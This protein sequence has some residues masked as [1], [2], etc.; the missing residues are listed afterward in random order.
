MITSIRMGRNSNDNRRSPTCKEAGQMTTR[1][2]LLIV[3][4]LLFHDAQAQTDTSH[5]RI[6]MLTCGIGNET[7]ET[8]GHTGI[9]VID[10]AQPIV[11]RDLVYNYGTFDY[12]DGS[13]AYKFL[14]GDL[15]V[16]LDTINYSFFE[17]MFVEEQRSMMEQVLLLN[18]EQKARLL[19]ALKKN[20]LPEN[21]YYT[22]DPLSNNCT[23]KTRDLFY[24]TFGSSIV[25]KDPLP[26]NKRPTLRNCYNSYYRNRYWEHVS[27]NL[28]LAS[29]MDTVISRRDIIFIPKLLSIAMAGAILNGK[30]VAAAPLSILEDHVTRNKGVNEPFIF[31]SLLALLTVVATVY[32]SFYK[33]RRFIYTFVLVFS[34]ILGCTL[35]Y[36][37][38][39]SDFDFTKNNFNLL[40]AFPLNVVVPFS[41]FKGSKIYILVG[42]ACITATILLHLLRVQVIPL[43][44]VAPFLLALSCAYGYMYRTGNFSCKSDN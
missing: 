43:L 38:F 7:F 34:G 21:R 25:F 24:E 30:K 16:Y 4:M 32:K 8:F 2:F 20:A 13:F 33:L 14:S 26:E 35:L 44:E 29:D 17:Q 23:T 18:G 40:W 31:T 15:E 27:I 10:S 3:G 11:R 12:F 28:L 39:C 6:S 42:I 36:F 9:R 41:K 1:L 19:S 5:L 37:W 22:Y